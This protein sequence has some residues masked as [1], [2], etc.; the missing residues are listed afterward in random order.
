MKKISLIGLEENPLDDIDITLQNI[1]E[2]VD[3]DEMSPSEAAFIKGW[4]EA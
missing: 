3:N 4:D 1:N 2:F